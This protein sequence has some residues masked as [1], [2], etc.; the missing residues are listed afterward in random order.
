VAL[1]MTYCFSPVRISKTSAL[2]RPG[3][4]FASSE[5]EA[6]VGQTVVHDVHGICLVRRE[7]EGGRSKIDEMFAARKGGVRFLMRA[8]ELR[9]WGIY[10]I[11]YVFGSVGLREKVSCLF[12]R[13][14]WWLALLVDTLHRE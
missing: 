2:E 9:R 10:P 7:D 1:L 11:S 6:S 8:K 5:D 13:F 4:S 12:S 14:D 3:C